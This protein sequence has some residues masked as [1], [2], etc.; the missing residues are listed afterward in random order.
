MNTAISTDSGKPLS[1]SHKS[2]TKKDNSC[3]AAAVLFLF[4]KD[5]S[6]D[7]FADDRVVDNDAVVL[8]SPEKTEELQ[9]SD[10]FR[11]F[12]FLRRNLPQKRFRIL[13][14]HSDFIDV[15]RVE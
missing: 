3:L 2:E 4:H 8:Y 6:A 1:I 11:V 13:F 10:R 15:V 14:Q 5:T 12:G 7:E 9:H